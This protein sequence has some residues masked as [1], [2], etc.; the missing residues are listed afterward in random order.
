M[1]SH[2]YTTN[3]TQLSVDLD[4][5][6]V[7]LL[8]F[9]DIV[10]V[11]YKI[12]PYNHLSIY[13]TMDKP[14]PAVEGLSCPPTSE[15]L[16]V[17]SPSKLS[18]IV[19]RTTSTQLRTMVDFY[20]TF[21]GATVAFENDKAAFLAYD[22]E[23][24]RVGILALPNVAAQA[25]SGGPKP[26]GLEHVAFTFKDLEELA[27]SYEQRKSGGITPDTC[28]NHG[29]TTSMYYS[30]PDGNRIEVEV[31]NFDTA[32]ES[33]MFMKSRSFQENPMG[34][35]FDPEEFVRRVR[36]GEDHRAIKTRID[37]GPRKIPGTA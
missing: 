30:D 22:N 31:D 37:V 11:F 25:V 18:H 13:S 9:L 19:L 36:S 2:R 15:L 17:I 8:S 5:Q 28:T 6:P 12:L 16:K 26:T 29:P 7:L 27:T 14:A 21:L 34:S 1:A 33:V 23:H 24:H 20:Q 35:D 32:E 4:V 10:P 3:L